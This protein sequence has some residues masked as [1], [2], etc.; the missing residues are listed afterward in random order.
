MIPVRASATSCVG[1]VCPHLPSSVAARYRWTA[2]AGC[3]MRICRDERNRGCNFVG[4][5]SDIVLQA[6]IVDID[7]EAAKHV[8]FDILYD[9]GTVP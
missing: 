6:S 4:E 9:E 1:N 8:A 3:C 2:M 7:I 5:D